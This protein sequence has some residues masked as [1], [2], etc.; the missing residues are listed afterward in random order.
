[1]GRHIYGP[2]TLHWHV[3]TLR[4]LAW[5]GGCVYTLQ[6]SVANPT[7]LRLECRWSQAL[8][9]LPGVAIPVGGFGASDCR[10]GCPAHLVAVPDDFSLEMLREVCSLNGAVACELSVL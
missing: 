6:A 2:G 9:S 8:S 4:R 10:S 5:V 3:D 7:G 1:M